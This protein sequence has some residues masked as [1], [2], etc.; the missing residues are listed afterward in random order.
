MQKI[1]SKHFQSQTVQAREPKFWCNLHHPLFSFVM[2]LISRVRCHVSGIMCQLSHVTCYFVKR[3]RKKT[4][5]IYTKKYTKK[6]VELVG[7]G[8]VIDWFIPSSFILGKQWNVQE[9][10]YNSFLAFPLKYETAESKDKTTLE[11]FSLITQNNVTLKIRLQC[12]E[13]KVLGKKNLFVRTLSTS[14]I[15]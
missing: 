6:V 8:S 9:H 4:I 1:P 3:R 5:K 7:G 13:Q 15:D 2:C 14:I 10:V 11:L 12:Y